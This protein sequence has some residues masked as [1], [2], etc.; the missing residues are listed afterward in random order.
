MALDGTYGFVYCAA[1]GVG[2]GVFKI[3]NGSLQGCDIFGG[4]YTG[5]AAENAD[6]SITVDL[7]FNV[8]AGLVLVQ[9]TSPQDVPH[10]RQIRQTL[11][12]DFG[13]G[14]PLEVYSPPGFIT[15]MIKRVDASYAP[16]AKTGNLAALIAQQVAA[17]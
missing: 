7:V 5:S 6:G 14:K 3:S 16:A 13:D 4:Q 12:T 10:Q 1:S 9:G 2:F 15:M 17:R 8:P 11:P